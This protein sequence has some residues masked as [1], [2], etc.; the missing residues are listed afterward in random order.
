M[1][2]SIM[3]TRNQ[4]SLAA[5]L[6]LLVFLPMGGL[7]A[8]PAGDVVPAQSVN[9]QWLIKLD[10]AETD[11]KAVA[12]AAGAQ[13]IGP[14]QGV[15]GYHRI[16]FL[17]QLKALPDRD[18]RGAVVR[19][20]EGQG[21]IIQFEEEVMIT[22]Y[23]KD[24]IPLDP[25]FAE[26]WHLENTG[27]SGGAEFSDIQV[28]RVWDAGY[29][30]Q[31]VIIGIVD[32]GTQYNHPDLQGNWLTGS[33]YDFN[34]N[35]SD[36]SPVGPDDRHGTSVTGIAAASNNSLGGLGVAYRSKF[37]PL[38]LIAGP[39]ASGDEAVAIS[40]RKQEIDIYNNSWGPSDE[41]G[42]RYAAISAVMQ[43]A[44]SSNVRTG[45]GGRGNIY[46]WAAG[47]GGLNGDNS[48]YDGYNALPWTIT[49]GAVGHD[50]IKTGYS[51]PG[52][53]L[54][55]VAPSGGRGGG[56]V[57]TDNTGF[58][59]Y[60]TGDY[61]DNF[62]GTSAAAPIVSGVAALILDARPELNWRD[63]QQIL[64]RTAVPV[65]FSDD[66]W[67]QNAAG[68]WISHKYGFGR[69]DAHAA[70]QL[71][72]NWQSLA[73]MISENRSQSINVPLPD[74]QTRTGSVKLT[75]DMEVQFVNVTLNLNH[76]DWGDI[77][78][79]LE[80]PSGTIRTLATPHANANSAGS[81]G[82]W[83]YLST[84]HLGEPSGGVWKLHVTD[85]GTGG[86]GTWS[87]WRIEVMGHSISPV[88][89][90]NPVG[91]DL[92]INSL[93]YPV[94]I[95]N[96]LDGIT[97]PD[98]DSIGIL[99]IQY[100]KFG[101]LTVLENG[102]FEYDMGETK[103]GT[104]SFS[105]LVGDGN[106]GVK[107]R[108]VTVLNPLPV[109]QDDLYPISA[110]EVANLPVLSNDRDPDEDPLRIISVTGHY[111]EYASIIDSQHIEFN[112][113][114]D[115]R[116]VVCLE[117]QVTDDS[118]GTA[119]GKVTLVIEESPEV[120]LEF[121]GEDDFARLPPTNQLLMSDKFTVEAWI[122]PESY[123]EYVTGF[124][125]IFD[126]D[127]FVF[128][129]NGV[130]HSFYNDRSLVLYVITSSGRPHAINTAANI[131]G[132]NRWQHV[133]VSYDS[134]NSVT[135]VRMYVDGE[136]VP[137]F[138]PS[139]V[140]ILK[141]TSPVQDNTVWPL[142][143]GE[144]SNGARAFMGKMAEFRIWNRVL[145]QSSI[146]QL[147]DQRMSGNETGLALYLP[148][149]QTL[150]PVAYSTG[151]FRGSLE[152]YEAQRVPLQL[153]EPGLADFYSLIA[154]TDNGW[155]Y[156]PALG[157]M[158][159]D[160]LPWI[161]S[162]RYQWLYTGH[163]PYSCDIR[164]YSASNGWR[165]LQTSEILFPWFYRYNDRKWLW[166]ENGSGSPAIFYDIMDTQYIPF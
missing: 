45:R 108:V 14:L 5:V 67:I 11:P 81:P 38:R 130:D 111:A 133:A 68:L 7:Q 119:S 117:Y 13:Y 105:I 113:P 72:G 75:S 96:V 160:Y 135:P 166:Y 138:Y 121:D 110:G 83:T 149:N 54:L 116:G 85:A 37:V 114:E 59:G 36:P 88:A 161:Y 65:D 50:D 74:N 60:S 41:V 35:D 106:G 66:D 164:V 10:E 25:L 26:Q 40:H 139:E 163:E 51:E 64:A 102:R 56:I 90:R 100:P 92:S 126:R 29:N 140:T 39:F 32:T 151:S 84:Q 47:N 12:E 150:E 28:R 87:S 157:W 24:F 86:S 48:N 27:Q 78:V 97:D 76:S 52:A 63:V 131:I 21:S 94:Q 118:D 1:Y 9:G 129:L 159:G 146:L 123:G 4:V 57:T 31:G 154:G 112:A 158:N 93:T 16:R 132:L 55:V 109:S 103:D 162:S 98:G 134:S 137:V 33:G 23:P 2:I 143:I 30:G 42:V 115:L 141:P 43:D 6:F 79:E 70:V 99:S 104:D 91:M 148:L 125:R 53:N 19:T 142:Y 165:W 15:S 145:N 155:H 124:G 34:D 127:T 18:V 153:G 46:V 107:R 69:V 49:V 82:E 20:L 128:F 136:P 58:S 17:Q 122:Y 61:F 89:N 156:N 8:A 147:H 44:L 3:Q 73:P 120:A 77:R 152:I 62:S 144:S 101:Q 71:A 95:D 80:S 22:R